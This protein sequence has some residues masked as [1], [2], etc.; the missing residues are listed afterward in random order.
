MSTT[1]EGENWDMKFLWFHYVDMV[2]SAVVGKSNYKNLRQSGCTPSK[3]FTISDETFV[4]VTI[5]NSYN[6]WLDEWNNRFNVEYKSRVSPLF[7]GEE[8]T[9]GKG[10]TWEK[11]GGPKEWLRLYAMVKDDRDK[12]ERKSLE[13]EYLKWI[14]EEN[15]ANNK[16]KSDEDSEN[17]KEKRVDMI[18][19]DEIIASQMESV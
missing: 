6:R 8:G 4:L 18:D 19:L 10:R 17:N 9:R 3:G 12:E 5:K 7:T 15:E 14:A 13:Q 16:K 2:M 1:T 11:S